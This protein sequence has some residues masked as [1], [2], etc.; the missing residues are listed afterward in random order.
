[1]MLFMLPSLN[2]NENP[3]IPPLPKGGKGGFSYF[4]VPVRAWELL[5][6][7]LM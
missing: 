2:L 3:P 1:M 4:V 6:D 5:T 7:Y